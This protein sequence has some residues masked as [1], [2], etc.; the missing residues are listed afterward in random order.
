M[1]PDQQAPGPPNATAT[2]QVQQDI[3]Q[4]WQAYSGLLNT[5]LNAQ[6]SDGSVTVTGTVAN[7]EQH[8]EALRVATLH[9]NGMRV[10]DKIKV[11]PQ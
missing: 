7:E 1:P 9:A 2:A 11:Q 10:I 4:A 8:Q 5:K 3:Q 6:V